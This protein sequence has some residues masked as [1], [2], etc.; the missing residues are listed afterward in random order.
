[1][2][3][4]TQI[5]FCILICSCVGH[6]VRK[7]S[8]TLAPAPDVLAGAVHDSVGVPVVGAF[9]VVTQAEGDVLVTPIVGS[10]L[11]DAKGEFR[12]NLP[13]AEERLTISIV[14]PDF[15]ASNL[16]DVDANERVAAK[17]SPI[18]G[19]HLGGTVV[20]HDGEASKTGTVRAVPLGGFPLQR[21]YFAPISRSGEYHLVVPPGSYRFTA[22]GPEGGFQI[23][24]RV[25]ALTTEQPPLDFRLRLKGGEI[26]PVEVAAWLK[27]KATSVDLVGMTVGNG[28]S[29]SRRVCDGRIVGVGETTH[30]SA[31]FAR[32]R[33]ALLTKLISDCGFNALLL[34]ADM[35][36]VAAIDDYVVSGVGDARTALW[37]TMRWIYTTEGYSEIVENIRAH[38]KTAA[39]KVR[40][41]GIDADAPEVAIEQL[42]NALP[43]KTYHEI[44]NKMSLEGF[45]ERY[46]EE[47]ESEKLVL[48][49]ALDDLKDDVEALVPTG[50]RNRARLSLRVLQQVERLASADASSKVVVREDF[51]AGNARWLLEVFAPGT[52]AMLAAHNGHVVYGDLYASR[53]LGSALQEEY[54]DKYVAMGLYFGR[55]GFQA[56]GWGRQPRGL[57][58]FELGASRPDSLEAFLQAG[59]LAAFFV[60]LSGAPERI[61]T[62]LKGDLP[63]RE[64]GSMFPGKAFAETIAVPA[65]AFDMIGYID[66]ISP[67]AQLPSPAN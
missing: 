20:K 66:Q 62:W 51:L 59:G 58:A 64:V 16:I 1:M 55:G 2:I 60:D 22:Q 21:A 11:T 65:L 43:D 5:G 3:R 34:E 44:L 6:T 30:G 12:M 50:R 26:R 45:A 49:S 39:T 8:A 47:S 57:R 28:R 15:V 32:F 14:H 67:N 36:S 4:I 31:E 40:V 37:T 56:V 24:R 48:R 53:S 17:L 54:G 46:A 41:F 9:L 10:A 61:L 42:R 33:W 52:K 29:L 13:S 18:D 35:A 23:K 19:V 38:N 27:A 25:V 63:S 7:T